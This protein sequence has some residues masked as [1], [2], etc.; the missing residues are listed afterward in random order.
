MIALERLLCDD[1]KAGALEADLRRFYP[2]LSLVE[3]FW[4]GGVS[5]RELVVLVEHLPAESS[6][7]RLIDP[8]LAWSM[9]EHL[10]AAAVDQLSAGNYYYLLAH[11]DKNGRKPE[12]PKPVPRP[13]GPDAEDDKLEFVTG[14]QARE[15]LAGIPRPGAVVEVS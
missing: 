1:A 4:R 15:I 2:G 3:S 13:E 5:P 7:A 12:A 8:R 9:G 14:A 11:T 10:L 6:L